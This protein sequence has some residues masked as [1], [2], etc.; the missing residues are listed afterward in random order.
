M[1]M[2]GLRIYLQGNNLFT[3]SKF[4]LWDPNLTGS[5]GGT[6]FSYPTT[7]VLSFGISASF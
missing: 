6:V 1:R 4:K 3:F 5:G 2:S 7:R